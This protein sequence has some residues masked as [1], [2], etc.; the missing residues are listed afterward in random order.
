MQQHNIISCIL[1]NILGKSVSYLGQACL[2]EITKRIANIERAFCELL[3]EGND[4]QDSRDRYLDVRRGLTLGNLRYLLIWER[5][6][7]SKYWK[8]ARHT[9]FLCLRVVNRGNPFG[10]QIFA[11]KVQSWLGKVTLFTGKTGSDCRL[12]PEWFRSNVLSKSRRA[13]RRLKAA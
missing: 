8:A 4:D 10:T 5:S 7:S 2:F 13:R 11:R 6:N 12:T 9:D 1:R 3:L